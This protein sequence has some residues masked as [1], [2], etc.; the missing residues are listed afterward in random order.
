LKSSPLVRATCVSALVLILP[1]ILLFVAGCVSVPTP[2][3]NRAEPAPLQVISVTLAPN[4][5]SLSP[6]QSQAFTATVANDSQNKGV[7]WTISSSA[8][9]GAGCG[10]LSA[11]VTSSGTAITYT[12][13]S[14][15]SS[16]FSVTL[17][18]TS[19]ADPEKSASATISL[20]AL[21]TPISILISPMSQTLRVGQTQTFTATVQN[22]TQNKGV[23]WTLSGS[24]CTGAACG[25]LSASASPSG[26]AITYTAPA[27]PPNPATVTL[28]ATSHADNTKSASA[29][30]TVTAAPAPI[31]VSVAPMSHSVQVSQSQ[32]F[33]AFVQNDAQNKGVTWTLS[34]AG[35]TAA[36]CG[37]LSAG[38]SASGTAITYTAPS[39]VPNPASVTLTATSVADSSKSSSASIT[40]TSAPT[41]I[42]VAVAPTSAS[43]QVNQMQSF[44][45]TVQND[46]QNKGVQWT[47]SGAGCSGSACGT[48]SASSSASGTAIVYTAPAA[49]PNPAS[50]T[51]TATSI[52]DSTKSS[53][54][55][56]TIFAVVT[57]IGV[58]IS[59]TTQ[60]VQVT[61]TQLFVATVQN[62]SQNKGVKWTLSGAGCSGAACGTLSANSSAS[63]AS[64]TYTAPAKVP[65]PATVKL[66]A[67]SVADST[68]STSSTITITAVAAI[69][70]TVSP[71]SASVAVHQTQIFS[72]TVQNDSQKKGVTWTLAGPGCSGNSCGSLSA[73][74]S[75]SGAQITYTA[76]ATVPNPATINL[77][78]TS[79]SDTSKSA[80]II[81]TITAAPISVTVSPT[82]PSVQVTKTQSFTATVQNDALNK[83]VTWAMEGDGC[84]TGAACGTLSATSSASGIAITYT[85]PANVPNPA[86]VFLTASS[87]TDPTKL[88]TATITLTPPPSPISVTVSP[89]S[90]S[91]QVSQTQKFTA[92]VQNDSQNKGVT[93]TI[94]G[95]G[96]SAAACGTLSATSSA[97]GSAITYT[98]PSAAP[99]SAT[100]KLTATSVTDSTR[101]DSS[102]ITI[103]SGPAI[104]VAVSP[105][106]TSVAV[107]RTHSFTA[108]VQND[109]QNK[110]VTWTLSGSGCTGTACGK[111]SGTSSASG[112]AI[113][114]TAPA[115]IPNPAT[116]TLTA[117]SA[118]DTTKTAS[119]T[120]TITPASSGGV[121][122][123]I[124]PK[125]GGLVLSQKLDFTAAVQ[126]DSANQ[127]VTWSASGGTFSKITST[128]ATYTAPSSPGVY[129]I[130]ATSVL[131][132]TQS[133]SATIGVTDLTGVTTYHND[134]ARD[135]VNSQEYAL[136]K[137][138]VTSSTFGKL[139]SCPVDAAIYAQPLWLANLSIGGG[140]HNVVFVVTQHDTV[141]AFD[142]DA[143]P[144]VTL[145]SKQLVPKGETW[146]SYLDLGTED[147]KPDIGIVGTPVIDP[148]TNTIYL[149][150]KTED[151]GRGCTPTANCHVRL[152]ALDITDGSETSSGPFE[153]TGAITVPGKGEGGNGTTVPFYPFH[154]NQR[155]GLALVNGTV[156]VCFGSHAD[157]RPYHGWVM[158]FSKS[159]IGAGPTAV[160]NTTPDGIEGGIWM[161]GGAPAFDSSGNLY[162][163]TGNGQ[164]DGNTN[165]GDTFLKLSTSNGL[166]LAD[167]MTPS[168]ESTMASSNM[169][170][171]AGG[172][173]ILA[174]LPTGS[175]R[176]VVIGGG[177]TGSGNY[178]EIY[179]LDRSDMGHLEGTGA[180]IVQK[181]P[182][183]YMIFAT[184]AY[185][186]DRFFIAGSGGPIKSFT[187]DTKAAQFDTVNIGVTNS[188]FGHP[189]AT[190][191]ISSNGANNGIVWAMNSSKFNT[192]ST[193]LYAFDAMNLSNK[194][195]DSMALPNRDQAGGAVKFTLPTIANGKV[196]VGTSSELDVYGLLP[197]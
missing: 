68:K 165:F 174:D 14:M 154:Q 95:S 152:H 177:K 25:T 35:C 148:S 171:G 192:P 102:T 67:T 59:P 150:S 38:S 145:W 93:W 77:T 12:A 26:T 136:T 65:S 29:S 182:L 48:L 187:F 49:V 184:G 110:G 52:A 86:T 20:K 41:T 196:Y 197:D 183:G 88:A 78:A 115:N 141:Y 194:L 121:S 51:L 57:N 7:S 156:F 176:H 153:M 189:G 24:G 40:I 53:S 60:S 32:T 79:V 4:T 132:V 56:I 193:I 188:K 191:S 71:T 43:I 73:T 161:S 114:Y 163:I 100:V 58:A 92:T 181:F 82:N 15:I 139:F 28:T 33:T 11:N 113:T 175:V 133:A 47:L 98:A 64:I 112:S 179:V 19:V 54:A 31:S 117:T 170:F 143:N 85:A 140:T 83:G 104:V 126:N 17:T 144:C 103:T 8:C 16:S 2:T 147:I 105:S 157:H 195:W 142:A 10:A 159:N 178:G 1:A 84:G 74:S 62:D 55:A 172:A 168:D 90:S 160:F 106:N 6:G 111:L 75:A 66:T 109:S 46:S 94:S 180:R 146:L 5:S 50:V 131:D 87:V 135:G 108:T 36:A 101:A 39:S 120:I 18:A 80:T 122:V 21:V 164:Y 63:G 138:N 149:V 42:S 30:I 27:T 123:T 134:L 129:T 23:T 107:S 81:I 9:T 89:A 13:P 190:P 118:A 128:S 99:S 34:G 69:A 130:T 185:W 116:V 124:S 167:W 127:G 137:S 173:A 97:S 70:V 91:V 119:A 151:A 76:P 162:A 186:Q 125:R 37:T 96:C 61:Q 45:A 3:T 44:T 158:A 166:S 155:A 169:D 72:A 22:D